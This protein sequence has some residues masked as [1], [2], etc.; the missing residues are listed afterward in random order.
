MAVTLLNHLVA[1]QSNLLQYLISSG[2]MPAALRQ[3]HFIGNALKYH[4][5]PF[6]AKDYSELLGLYCT[7]PKA[8]LEMEKCSR[9]I[10]CG[11]RKE[12]RTCA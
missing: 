6:C 5:A 4:D 9:R 12:L 3:H 11:H 10:D 8:A 2:D 1:M 7:N